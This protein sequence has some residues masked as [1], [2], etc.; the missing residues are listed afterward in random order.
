MTSVRERQQRAAARARLAKQMAER[1]ATAKQRR[2]RKAVLVAG[3][4]VLL[5]AVGTFWGVTTLGGDDDLGDPRVLPTEEPF[6]PFDPAEPAAPGEC[7]W[8]PLDPSE[9]YDMSMLTE[10]GTPEVP[11]ELP[12]GMATM[13]LATNLGDIEIELDTAAVPCTYANFAHLAEH[14]FYQGAVCHRMTDYSPEGFGFI[15]LQCG[16]PTGTGQGGPTYRFA[17]ENLPVDQAPHYPR[18]VVAM[19]KGQQP[20]TTGSQFFFIYE[21]IPPDNLPPEYTVL[22]TI[23]SGMDIVDDVVEGGYEGKED[24]A[25]QGMPNVELTIESVTVTDPA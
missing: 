24:G 20:G 23:T 1:Q 13:T 2:Q 8:T 11:E 10:V 6:D 18:G 4:V 14:D 21:D 16:D 15:I 22:G 7:G 19:A 3:I 12:T 9:G 25:D 5:V 17:E